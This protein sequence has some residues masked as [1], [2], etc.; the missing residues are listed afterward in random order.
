M[1]FA[2]TY[3]YLR[4][5]NANPPHNANVDGSDT[6]VEF[7]WEAD[8]YYH[9][10]RAIITIGD[11]GSVDAGYYGNG[12]ELDR[13]IDVEFHTDELIDL[14]DGVPIRTNADWGARCYDVQSVSFGS[15]DNYVLARWTFALGGIPLRTAPGDRFVFRVNDDLRRLESHWFQLQGVQRDRREF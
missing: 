3:T 4:N 13:G 2:P 6:P 15:G 7:T 8:G 14:L 10:Y 11:R 5:P 12:L 9:I 1:A